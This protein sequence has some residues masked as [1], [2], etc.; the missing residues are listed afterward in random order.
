M[1]QR[2]TVY[3]ALSRPGVD[4]RYRSTIHE[5]YFTEADSRQDA[6]QKAGAE[7]AR[8]HVYDG[9]LIRA[10]VQADIRRSARRWAVSRYYVV[11][12][13]RAV[14]IDEKEYDDTLDLWHGSP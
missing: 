4:G 8:Y 7:Y 9:T 13:S 5:R 10:A 1:V 14:E 11:R 3:L 2:Y 12:A 6:I